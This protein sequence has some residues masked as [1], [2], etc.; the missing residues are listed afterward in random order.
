V[1]P[2]D[3]HVMATDEPTPPGAKPAIDCATPA[4]AE[5]PRAAAW[6]IAVAIM[7]TAC[8]VTFAIVYWAMGRIRAARPPVIV[9]VPL[10]S[11]PAFPQVSPG[12]GPPADAP[13]TQGRAELAKCTMRLQHIASALQAWANR[14][15]WQLPDRLED[16]VAAGLLNRGDLVCPAGEAT[17]GSG[18][19]SAA[20]RYVGKGLKTPVAPDTVVVYEPPLHVGGLG[21]NVLFGDG[22]VRLLTGDDASRLLAEAQT[23][24]APVRYSP[25][26]T[27]SGAGGS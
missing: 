20:Y 3:K 11:Q 17:S 16:L 19:D 9:S 15:D 25:T 26:T 7:L 12:S 6:V 10:G 18:T 21:M 13:L 23:G 2:N 4:R 14:H 5:P 8:V 24:R 1:F 22:G 27:P